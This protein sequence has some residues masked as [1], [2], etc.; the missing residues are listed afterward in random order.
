MI[1][2]FM[3]IWCRCDTFSERLRG[4][5]LNLGSMI[6]PQILCPMSRE[7]RISGVTSPVL[8]P[9]R[10]IA[11]ITGPDLDL[12]YLNLLPQPCVLSTEDLLPQSTFKKAL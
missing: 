3:I 8:D 12:R 4:S 7:E 5:A 6:P 1:Y 9:G 2:R 10:L 11:V